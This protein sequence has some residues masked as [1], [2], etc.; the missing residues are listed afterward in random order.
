MK[1]LIYK[2]DHCGKQLNGM[3]DYTEIEIEFCGDKICCDLCQD[4]YKELL[5]RTK[6]F[7]KGE[8]KQNTAVAT[9][10]GDITKAC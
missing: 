10:D 4:C 9:T 7:V 1:N 3:K 6:D 8:F 5:K 2:C